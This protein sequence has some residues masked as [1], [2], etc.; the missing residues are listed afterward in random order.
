MF[1]LSRFLFFSA[2]ADLEE[3]LKEFD[4]TIAEKQTEIEKEQDLLAQMQ[5]T[6]S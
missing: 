3:L 6:E 1:L 5:V 2:Q 4:E